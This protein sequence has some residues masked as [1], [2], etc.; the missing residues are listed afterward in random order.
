VSLDLYVNGKRHRLYVDMG[1]GWSSSPIVRLNTGSPI[2]YRVDNEPGSDMQDF[3]AVD[4][5]IKFSMRM[6]AGG[7][8]AGALRAPRQRHRGRQHRWASLLGLRACGDA[9]QLAPRREA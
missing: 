5:P 1:D 8:G 9:N 3:D 7:S 2:M 4:G 6:G